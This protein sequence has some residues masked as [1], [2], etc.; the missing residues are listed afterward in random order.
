MCIGETETG[1]ILPPLNLNPNAFCYTLQRIL[2]HV[3]SLPSKE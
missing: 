3:Q 1:V 2:C